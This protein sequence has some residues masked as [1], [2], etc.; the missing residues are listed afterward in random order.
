MRDN[1]AYT[2]AQCAQLAML[3]E[4]ST[5]PKPGNVDRTHDFED[6]TFEHF[7][8]SAVGA[9]PALMRAASSS[10]GVGSLI[11]DAVAGSMRWHGG[12]NTHFGTFL[13]LIPLCMAAGVHTKHL[14]TPSLTPH[15][16][17]SA[18]HVVRTTTVEDS[19]DFLEAF[20]MADVR[21][22]DV[23]KLDIKQHETTREI[24]TRQITLFEL[25]EMSAKYDLVAREWV[26]GFERSFED[27]ER[28]RRLANHYTINEAVLLV[29]IDELAKTPDT[30]I[31]AKL[32]DEVAAEV[33][34]RARRLRSRI[35]SIGLHEAMHM[36]E[37]FDE[38]LISARINPGSTADIMGAGLFIALLEGMVV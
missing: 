15:L 28:I 24:Q 3:L 26:S 21:V 23:D 18:Y 1:E 22:K 33:H 19:L 5:T 30:F 12:G 25:M 35:D 2:I 13:L 10:F 11:R 16:R 17:S 8:A 34:E 20:H 27:A 37:E 36:I 29:F 31:A 32:G 9:L 38:E 14:L 7:L 4:V 6:T